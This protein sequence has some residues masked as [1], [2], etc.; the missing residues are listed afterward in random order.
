MEKLIARSSY[1]LGIACL[2]IAVIWR[3][4]NIFWSW[5]SS[6]STPGP[7]LGHLAFLHASI[8]FLV[9]TIATV[10]Y[11]WLNSQKP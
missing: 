8:L 6:A 5:H 1:W 11:A 9:A 7:I 10:G 3:I 2:I 4:V